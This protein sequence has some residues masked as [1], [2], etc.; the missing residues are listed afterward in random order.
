VLTGCL[1]AR[2]FPVLLR[3]AVFVLLGLSG[4]FAVL[5]GLSVLIGKEVV[6]DQLSLGLPWLPWHVRF[7]C[8]SGFSF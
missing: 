2:R 4:V 1:E 5:A 6:T 8:L 7:D 3:Q